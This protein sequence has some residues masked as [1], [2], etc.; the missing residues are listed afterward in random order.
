M[1]Q[2]IA[3]ALGLVFAIHCGAEAGAGYE[4]AVRG[5]PA[6]SDDLVEAGAAD[7]V[8][9]PPTSEG[10]LLEA[11][12][13]AGNSKLLGKLPV[14]LFSDAGSDA[15]TV[16]LVPGALAAKFSCAVIPDGDS[17][18]ISLKPPKGTIVVVKTKGLLLSPVPIEINVTHA[19]SG[20]SS[21]VTYTV[22]SSDLVDNAAFWEYTPLASSYTSGDPTFNCTAKAKSGPC[23]GSDLP[24]SSFP[25]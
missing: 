1:R 18:G 8:E 6:G 4:T 3:C 22:C 25:W 17:P 5:G 21:T 20:G 19:P 14:T 16:S 7:I 11:A 23:T 2:S 15:S 24:V 13:D 12:E 10:E 9:T